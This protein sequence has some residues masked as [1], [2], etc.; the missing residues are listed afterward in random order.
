ME[1]VETIEDEQEDNTV[2][3]V[4][5]VGYKLH[6]RLIRPASVVVSTTK[7]ENNENA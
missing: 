5:R 7:K 1:A 2:L 3:K 6:E 4:T